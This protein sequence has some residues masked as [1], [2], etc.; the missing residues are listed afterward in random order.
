MRCQVGL[1]VRGLGSHERPF[2][3]LAKQRFLGF[4]SKRPY[5]Y[6]HESAAMGKEK[7]AYQL[8]TPKGTK[9]CMAATS[10]TPAYTELIRD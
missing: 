4:T 10:H 6:L 7:T 5:T 9:D 8:K 3:Q 1:I 2:R